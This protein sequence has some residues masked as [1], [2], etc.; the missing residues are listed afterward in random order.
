MPARENTNT[1]PKK[2]QTPVGNVDEGCSAIVDEGCSAIVDEGC[3]ELIGQSRAEQSRAYAC[4]FVGGGGELNGNMAVSGKVEYVYI[5][6]Y[7]GE[8]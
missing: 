3:S 7:G 6:E 8:W 5:Y 1:I 4:V 2:I